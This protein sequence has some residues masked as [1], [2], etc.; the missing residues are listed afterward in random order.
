M[1]VI[2]HRAFVQK[3]S[4]SDIN[5]SFH[6]REINV[7]LSESP[8]GFWIVL[9]DYKC[10]KVLEKSVLIK[11]CCTTVRTA[12]AENESGVEVDPCVFKSLK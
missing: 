5:H 1:Y 7:S 9:C 10:I 11:P 4:S 2:V 8:D 12:V 6:Q 3:S